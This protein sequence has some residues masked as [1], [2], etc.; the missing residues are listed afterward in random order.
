MALSKVHSNI[1]ALPCDDN[2]LEWHYM[3]KGPKGSPYEGG[4]YH[5]KLRFPASTRSSRQQSTC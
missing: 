5:G 3:I 1:K 4:M 2:I